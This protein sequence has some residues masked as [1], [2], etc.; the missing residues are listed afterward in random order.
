MPSEFDNDAFH[1]C[2]KIINIYF[3]IPVISHAQLSRFL[4][5]LIKQDPQLHSWKEK[6]LNEIDT[7]TAKKV[8]S[9]FNLHNIR[10]VKILLNRILDAM[11]FDY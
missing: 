2:D 1:Y 6:S 9:K 7:E 8:I 10:D 4:Y 11:F 3:E 5:K